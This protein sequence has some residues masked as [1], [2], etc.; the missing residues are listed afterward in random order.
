MREKVTLRN[1]TDDGKRKVGARLDLHLANTK[2]NHDGI[3]KI[4]Q[5]NRTCSVV[6]P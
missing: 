4:E 5:E 3:K 1:D 6:L 2:D